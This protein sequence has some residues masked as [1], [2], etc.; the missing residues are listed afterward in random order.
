[1]REAWRLAALAIVFFLVRQSSSTNDTN[2][3]TITEIL[4]NAT[5]WENENYNSTAPATDD[6][7]DDDHDNDNQWTA[8]MSTTASPKT[9]PIYKTGM[10]SSEEYQKVR[11]IQ[12]W[13]YLGL[14]S[15]AL[16]LMSLSA[17]AFLQDRHS[18]SNVYLAAICLAEAWYMLVL[19]THYT[20]KLRKECF[21]S[22]T[23]TQISIW[24]VSYT[25]MSARRCVYV[26]NALVSVQR[27]VAVA[28]PIQ[29]RYVRLL[30]RPRVPLAL[31]VILTFLIHLYRPLQYTTTRIQG[32]SPTMLR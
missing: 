3:T 28:F 1:M 31:V 14:E 29:A 32:I 11:T 24:S 21:V 17:A 4:A 27:F 8:D 2:H 12:G 18:P 19:F 26:L 25:G 5:I 22:L 13:V 15:F 23:Y 7:D 16:V 30:Q 6:N 10:M 20:C 9:L